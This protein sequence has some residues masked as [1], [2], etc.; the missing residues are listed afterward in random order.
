M[1]TDPFRLRTLKASFNKLRG[2]SVCRIL[3]TKTWSTLSRPKPELKTSL[4]NLR[5][6]LT[7]ANPQMPNLY[8]VLKGLKPLRSSKIDIKALTNLICE[9]FHVV[10]VK[11]Y[12]K[13]SEPN[14]TIDKYF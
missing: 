6:Y 12:R 1:A 3:K 13:F 14:K 7:P 4:S 8:L 2:R 9:N 5:T 11:I 10:D